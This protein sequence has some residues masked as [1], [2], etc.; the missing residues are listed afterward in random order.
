MFWPPQGS[1]IDRKDIVEPGPD[2]IPY[3]CRILRDNIGKKIFCFLIYPAQKKTSAL[4]KKM[5]ITIVLFV[6]V[7]HNTSIF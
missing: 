7:V 6:S 5:L 3:K 2:W 4:Q 1:G